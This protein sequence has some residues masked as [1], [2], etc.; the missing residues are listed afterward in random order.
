MPQD[1][2]IRHRSGASEFGEDAGSQTPLSDEERA[3]LRRLVRRL[4]V[5]LSAQPA[6]TDREDEE[7]G[8][9]SSGDGRS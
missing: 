2:C 6:Q 8:A 4:S 1:D 3:D 5:P 9:S 7:D